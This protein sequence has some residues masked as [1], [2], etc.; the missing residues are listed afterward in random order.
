VKSPVA[1]LILVGVGV[2][3]LL[4]RLPHRTDWRPLAPAVAAAAILLVTM[5]V[6]IHLGVRHILA[7][8]PLLSIA[9]GFG[10]VSLWHNAAHPRWA[11]AATILLLGWMIATSVRAHPDY[12]PYFNE[13]PGGH[14]ER[15]LVDSDLDWGQDLWR[16][17][18]ALRSRKVDKL[19]LSYLGTADPSRHGLPPFIELAPFKPTTGWIAISMTNLKWVSPRHGG[20]YLWLE[21]YKPVAVAGRSIWLYHI[22]ETP[23]D[24]SGKTQPVISVSH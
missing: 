15:I 12:L 9:A 2:V 20:M 17:G 23:S 21:A 22:P 5:P 19:T 11:R 1:F 7:V 13:L 16:L 3:I 8:Y 6:V 24:A 4:N 10:A 14:P 18:E